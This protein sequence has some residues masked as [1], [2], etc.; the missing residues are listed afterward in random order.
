MPSISRTE[1]CM[2]PFSSSVSSFSVN[3]FPR[4]EIKV[5][6]R[7]LFSLRDAEKS[8]L[9]QRGLSSPSI[10]MVCEGISQITSN[11]SLYFL[12]VSLYC[13]PRSTMPTHT[14]E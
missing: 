14:A 11:L 9:S 2:K 6:Y 13:S 1:N 4:Q 7:L 5:W 8:L 12:N 10:S 3:A